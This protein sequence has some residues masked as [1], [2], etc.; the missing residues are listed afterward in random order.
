M[1]EYYSSVYICHIIFIHSSIDGH[2]GCFHLLTI[3]NNAS[4]SMGGGVYLFKLVSSFSSAKHPGVK[5]LD[6]MCCAVLSLLV[7]SNSL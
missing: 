1:A 3:I 7:V 2:L 6:Y 5:L 4:V